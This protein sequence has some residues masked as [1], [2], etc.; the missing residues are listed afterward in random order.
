MNGVFVLGFGLLSTGATLWI[1]GYFRQR[2]AA[3]QGVEVSMQNEA[4]QR[5]VQGLMRTYPELVPTLPETSFEYKDWFSE[6]LKRSELRSRNKTH[7]EGLAL[8]KQVR[9]CCEEWLKITQTQKAIYIAAG[10]GGRGSE[11]ETRQHEA[12]LA[13][14]DLE[15]ARARAEIANLNNPPTA[16]PVA[17]RRDPVEDAISKILQTLRTVA[18]VEAECEQLI[19]DHPESAEFI[20]HECRR[21]LMDLRNRR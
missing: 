14:L 1:M 8:L 10:Q 7:A 11:I 9:E 13:K 18:G 19:K 17:A 15:I 2:Q 21:I 4:F 3:L 6:I 12:T 20:R 16:T 5:H